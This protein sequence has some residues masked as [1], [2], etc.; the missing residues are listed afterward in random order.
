MLFTSPRRPTVRTTR[1]H[2]RV[3]SSC[4]ANT[5]NVD[6]EL[7]NHLKIMLFCE[8]APNDA[9]MM[10]QLWPCMGEQGWIEDFL[11]KITSL[12][13]WIDA[14][15]HLWTQ[16]CDCNNKIRVCFFRANPLFNP[17]HPQLWS[18]GKLSES[19]WLSWDGWMSN[20]RPDPRPALIL[21]SAHQDIGR[22][23]NKSSSV[24]TSGRGIP[25]VKTYSSSKK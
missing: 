10:C 24:N 11:P 7:S 16:E 6:R 22:E 25:T 21:H 14:N 17:V 9:W 5:T 13:Y 4:Q 12:V 3:S 20:E 8:D 18:A 1:T 19:R 23:K 2:A 15:P